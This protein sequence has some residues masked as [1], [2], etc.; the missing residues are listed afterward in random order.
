MWHLN[1]LTCKK[2]KIGLLNV[3]KISNQDIT[4]SKLIEKSRISLISVTISNAI[5]YSIYYFFTSSGFDIIMIHWLP[6][7]SIIIT[8]FILLKDKSS[9]VSQRL[10]QTIKRVIKGSID[11]SIRNNDIL[12]TDTFT[13]YN[14]V[15]VDFLIYISALIL[16]MPTLP[17]GPRELSK[18]HLQVFNLDL[19]LANFPSFLRL[20]QC[21]KEYNQSNR[22][23]IAHLLNAIKYSTAFFPTFAMILF[24]NG[25]FKTLG[26]W[27]F[28]TFV[29]SA[30]SLYWDITNDWNFG[31]FL[32]F[33]S[34]K[35]NIKILRNKLLYAKT[36]YIV[37]ILIDTQL[38]FIWIYRL[39]YV[40]DAVSE[41]STAKFFIMLFTTE[42]GNFILEILEI[43]RRW[44]WVFLKVETEYIK[45]SSES[46]VIELQNFD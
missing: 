4:L 25:V 28:F 17:T 2:F 18:S 3:L 46:N 36:A 22:Q 8:F 21:L 24:K 19:L 45:M 10:S 9:V 35:P 39:F 31:F 15:L 7:I 34:N 40:G 37:A 33:L 29:N 6:L 38:R 16:G 42:K 5:N 30:Y 11:V 12:L 32:K 13:S 41:S 26:C 1:L 14:K 20:K 44:V 23:N 27:Y 43:F